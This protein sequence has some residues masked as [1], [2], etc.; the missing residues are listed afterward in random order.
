MPI[1]YKEI[2]F[3]LTLGLSGMLIGML[4]VVDAL[5]QTHGLA[6]LFGWRGALPAPVDV[7]II[8]IDGES[9]SRLG[10]PARP[11]QWPRRLHAQLIHQLLQAGASTIAFDLLFD[12]DAAAPSQDAALAGA[13]RAAGN[14]LLVESLLQEQLVVTG[15]GGDS[16]GWAALERAVLPV[17]QLLQAALGSAALPLPREERVNAAWFFKADAGASPSLPSLALQAHALPHYSLLR[18]C[19]QRRD[20]AFAATLPSSAEDIRRGGNLDGLMLQL[21]RHLYANPQLIDRLRQ[22]LAHDATI[23]ARSAAT[24]R[25]LLALYAGPDARHLNFYGPPRTITTI[26]YDRAVQGL[27]WPP[28]GLRGKA[29]FVG[30]SA[31]SANEQDR[32]RDDYHTVFSRDDGWQL[33]GVEIGATAF[34][35]LLDDT[36]VRPLDP[37]PRLLLLFG[38]GFLL[39]LVCRCWR[40]SHAALAVA[41]AGTGY[42]AAAWVL[43]ARGQLWLPLLTP[44][45]LQVPLALSSAAVLRYLGASRQRDKIRHAF[46]HF[47]PPAMVEQLA[48]E[49]RSLQAASRSCHGV[50]LATDAAGYT[51]LAETMEPLALTALMNR[52]YATLFA[53]VAA[54]GGIVS[55]VKGDAMLALWTGHD[56]ERHL[57]AHACNAALDIDIALG[58]LRQADATSPVLATRIGLDCGPLTL[59]NVGAGQHYEYRA[60]GDTVNTASRIECLNRQL[61]TRV[62]AS[63][64]VVDGLDEFVLRPL[65]AFL[66]PGKS[67][68]VT[69]VEI[70]ARRDQQ[71]WQESWLCDAFAAAL[72]RFRQQHWPQAAQ[73]FTAILQVRPDDGPSSFY[74]HQ[75]VRNITA[76]PPQPWNAVIRIDEK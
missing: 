47:V 63:Q 51:S 74:L 65:G 27:G 62:L 71:S 20:P 11:A 52:Y 35:N 34:A 37:I 58:K 23:D 61:G 50:C 13:M 26:P 69:V 60:V 73:A 59:G 3:A 72:D 6:W 19:L 42:L 4:P 29:V 7:V 68:P 18:Q 48:S 39:A 70:R 30:Y 12:H 16:V 44:L 28:G 55:D 24:L 53:P 46:S 38:W 1:Q 41:L 14:V 64:A 40:V 67:R 9:A 17:A 57:R 33:S 49:T 22:D 10:L 32:I 43:F 21:R 25:A 5:E 75:C 8:A 36:A 54:R 76:V 56:S 45:L 66:L 31:A 15:T 2:L